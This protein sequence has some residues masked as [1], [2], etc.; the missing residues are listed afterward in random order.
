MRIKYAPKIDIFSHFVL[1]S[2]SEKE[3]QEN[4]YSKIS[5]YVRGPNYLIQN[6]S[7]INEKRAL[8]NKLLE[9]KDSLKIESV[10]FDVIRKYFALP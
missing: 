10:L 3:S 4:N 8:K 2:S 7:Q 5:L 6:F 1:N 9:A